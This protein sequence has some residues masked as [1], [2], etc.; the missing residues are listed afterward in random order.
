MISQ[1]SIFDDL[2]KSMFLA[3]TETPYQ[4]DFIEDF[5]TQSQKFCALILR[6]GRQE[7]CI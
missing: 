3:L 4:T 6:G 5:L 1:S 2:K 7:A